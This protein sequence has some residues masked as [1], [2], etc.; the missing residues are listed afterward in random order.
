MSTAAV[1]ALSPSL[2]GAAE[3]ERPAVVVSVHDIAPATRERSARIIDE[4]ARVGVSCCSLLVVPN[5]H[6]RGSSFAEREFVSWLRRLEASGHEIVVH[7]Y[8]HAR[9]ASDR[10]SFRD[11]VVTRVYTN[12]EGEFYDLAYDEAFRRISQARDE[13][14]S[15]GLKPHGFIAPA[16]LLSAE[17][18]QAARDCDLEYTTRLRSVRDLRHGHTYAAR[19]LV[20]SVRTPLRRNLSRVWNAAL[21]RRCKFS[22]LL[23]ISVHPVDIDYPRVWRQITRFVRAAAADRTATTYGDWVARMRISASE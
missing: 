22:P 4:L 16:W 21:F 18:E 5:Y 14:R 11:R 7:G 6:Q 2:I 9:P 8:Y 1:T 3:A 19:S 20:Y 15:A 23:R 17:A 13:F 10:E 12:R